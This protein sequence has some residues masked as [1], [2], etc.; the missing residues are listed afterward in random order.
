MA[1]LT[2][3][4]NGVGSE[5]S[6][7]DQYP[8]ASNHYL[9]VDEVIAN[10]DGD[11]VL[12]TEGSET[13]YRDLYA[14]ENHT[15]E[16]GVINSVTIYYRIKG[17]INTGY[18]KPSQK[19]GVTV[20]DG[21]EQSSGSWATK[22]QHYTLNPATGAAYTWD[23]I[24]ALQV[25]IVIRTWIDW[26]AELYVVTACTQVYIEVDYTPGT[27]WT[28]SLA[29]TMAIASSIVKGMGKIRSDSVAITSPTVE[30]NFVVAFNRGFSDGV[31]IADNLV[32]TWVFKRFLTD[33]LVITE[34]TV[35]SMGK[36]VTDSLTMTDSLSKVSA[37]K[38]S[39]SD[40]III[41]DI[42]SK[43]SAFKRTLSDGMTIADSRS[44]AISIPKVDVLPIV[45]SLNKQ[46]SKV[47]S[48]I[49]GLVDTIS[50]QTVLV[51]LDSLV[52]VDTI[53][54][55]IGLRKT[56]NINITDT[57]STHHFGFGSGLSIFRR[58]RGDQYWSKRGGR[59]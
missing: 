42:R 22:H 11:Y 17:N 9:Y 44:K 18:G 46:S 33:L 58:P 27:A 8:G 25:G 54:K 2:L 47:L 13:S 19:S 10:D 34:A 15:T 3:R 45:D 20:T 1:T 23:E 26:G 7:P 30:I 6:I 32:K 21:T 14:F 29:D 40:S 38:R 28:K 37:F 59:R 36:I 48:D 4:P 39:L 41:T 12:T 51:K 56:D 31:T 57:K 5:T 49:V 53:L 16:N 35:K 24:D 52:I 43:V 50:K 55:G